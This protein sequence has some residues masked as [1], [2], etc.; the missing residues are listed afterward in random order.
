MISSVKWDGNSSLLL[1]CCE[2][3]IVHSVKQACYLAEGRFVWHW[4][5]NRQLFCPIARWSGCS[6]SCYCCD[7]KFSLYVTWC[8]FQCYTTLKIYLPAFLSEFPMGKDP[9]FCPGNWQ[10]AARWDSG[11][12]AERSIVSP[13]ASS[14]TLPHIGAEGCAAAARSPDIPQVEETH[15]LFRWSPHPLALSV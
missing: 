8:G 11:G 3:R 13:G 14:L 1:G 9:G 6:C 10:G 12:A 7:A 15:L 5:G 2:D 4:V